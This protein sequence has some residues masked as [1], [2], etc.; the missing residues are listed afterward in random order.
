MLNIY[1][2]ILNKIFK[3]YN[4]LESTKRNIIRV[5]LVLDCFILLIEN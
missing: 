1:I 5:C 3:I 2:Y 4:L